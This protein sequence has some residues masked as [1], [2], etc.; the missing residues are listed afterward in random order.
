[1]VKYD[2][3]IDLRDNNNLPTLRH[4]KGSQGYKNEIKIFLSNR[5]EPIS[6]FINRL[7]LFS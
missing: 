6:Y 5:Q 4:K 2:K 3:N 7:A 1:M